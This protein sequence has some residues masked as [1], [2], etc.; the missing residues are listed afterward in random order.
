MVCVKLAG[1]AVSVC[2]TEHVSV[3]TGCEKYVRKINIE[4]KRT[5]K[6]KKKTHETFRLIGK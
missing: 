6:E 2:N 5:V 4:I 3:G 1:V